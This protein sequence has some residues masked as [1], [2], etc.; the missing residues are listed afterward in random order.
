MA[1]RITIDK[2]GRVV[3][4]K[5]LRRELGVVAGAKLEATAEGGR[6]VIEPLANAVVLVEEEGLLVATSPSPESQL[7]D[8]DVLQAID[9]QRRWPNS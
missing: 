9:E 6:L 4:P 7:T 8:S 2:A 1:M 3:I 5:E